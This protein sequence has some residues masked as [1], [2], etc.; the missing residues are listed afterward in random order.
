[1][2]KLSVL[3]IINRP[4]VTGGMELYALNLGRELK[5]A[6]HRVTFALRRGTDLYDAASAGGFDIIPIT[7]GGALQ[8]Y[9]IFS[10]ARFLLGVEC[11]VLH[12]HTGNDYW[13]P[14][15]AKWLTCSRRSRV[16]VTRHILSA[17]RGFSSK[18]YF[19]HVD[20]IC[21]S[22][23]VYET[24]RGF[25][26]P[27]SRL[28]M[29]YPGIDRAPF[30]A[31]NVSPFYRDKFGIDPKEF[32]IASM[33]KWFGRS[34][35][36]LEKMLARFSDAKV[37]IAGELK[38]HEKAAIENSAFN[39][40]VFVCG[41]IRNMAEFYR[42]AD[43]FVFPSFDEA[44]GLVVAEAMASGLPVLTASTGGASE[45][46]D[47]GSCGYKISI[48]DADGFVRAA[49]QIKTDPALARKLGENAKKLARNY[50]LA[51]MAAKIEKAY[52]ESLS[53]S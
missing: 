13:P 35:P 26:A 40:R 25:S 52:Y 6:G 5:K 14:L 15:L 38:A 43:I 41:V 3:Q 22:R 45:I 19:Q 29:I 16:F 10:I 53:V 4:S 39:N 12:A 2:K 21:V 20:T 37:I 7:R 46:F 47:N 31:D 32:V 50:D 24:M 27:G 44:F 33:H 48:D 8:P 18:F 9:N 1:M 51:E 17:P 28:H 34:F 23:S 30:E 11:D 49:E 42:S 36:I